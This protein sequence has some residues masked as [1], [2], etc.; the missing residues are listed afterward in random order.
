[1]TSTSAYHNTGMER[2]RQFKTSEKHTAGPKSWFPNSVLFK[3]KELITRTAGGE[4]LVISVSTSRWWSRYLTY[5]RYGGT[6]PNPFFADLLNQLLWQLLSAPLWREIAST[7]S[8]PTAAVLNTRKTPQLLLTDVCVVAR[9]PTGLIICHSDCEITFK[10]SGV[11]KSLM[12]Q[13]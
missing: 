9:C 6:Q 10:I 11:Q 4:M 7:L 13:W 3:G 8:S 1:M 12:P 2:K 5:G